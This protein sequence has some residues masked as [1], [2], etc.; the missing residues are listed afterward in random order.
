M[1]LTKRLIDAFKYEGGW[2][3]RW[4]DEVPGFGVRIYPSGKKAFV[5]SY[6]VE[7]NKRLMVL[8]RFGADLTLDQARNKAREERVKVRGGLDPLEEK[9]NEGQKKTFSGLAD[10]YFAEHS[11]KHKRTWKEDE[12]RLKQHIPPSWKKK[13]AADIAHSDIE[14]LHSKIGTDRGRYEANRLLSLLRH[15]FRLARRWG[16]V[17]GNAAN[18]AA[19][20]E[21]FKEHKRKRWVRPDEVPALA[22]AIDEESNVYVRSALWLYLLT[23]LRKTELLQTKRRDVDWGRGQ[24]RLPLTKAGEEQYATLSAPALAIMQAIPELQGNTFLLPGARKGQH[25]VNIS[26]P[27]R[28]VRKRAT[29][30]LWATGPEHSPETAILNRL[31]DELGRDPTYDECAEAAD[32]EEIELPVGLC[33]ARLHDLRRTVGSWLTQAGVDL[34]RIKDALRHADISTT[35]IYARLGED[36]AREAMEDHGRRIMEAAGRN[37]RVGVAGG[38]G[39]KR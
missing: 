14:S 36:A 9:K 30:M 22:A 7:G 18:P 10:Q 25:L 16:F 8:G 15:M 12:R 4:D 17:D 38:G 32:L 6:R 34:N 2:D 29:V 26:V 1:K 23:G 37:E 35:L 28:R 19:D 20:V 27:W 21:K 5:L 11:K 33:D 3:V 24:I 39:N 31:R 13:K